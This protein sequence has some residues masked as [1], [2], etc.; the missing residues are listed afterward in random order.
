MLIYVDDALITS[1]DSS[2]IQDIINHLGVTFAL[3]DLGQL[4]Y[5]LGIE[6]K[7]FTGGLFLSQARYIKDLLKWANMSHASS[8]FTPIDVKVTPHFQDNNLLNATQ[9]RS[10]TGALQ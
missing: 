4:L 1:F 2:L 9:C 5:F 8:I 3:K 7:Y 6:A 10:S